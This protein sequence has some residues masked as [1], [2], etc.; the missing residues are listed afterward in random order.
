MNTSIHGYH[1]A[2]QLPEAIGNSTSCF[3]RRE[4]IVLRVEGQGGTSGWGEAS[5]MRR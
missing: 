4:A 1:L 3:D 5:A 2:F